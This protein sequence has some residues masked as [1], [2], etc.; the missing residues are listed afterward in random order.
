MTRVQLFIKSVSEEQDPRS[1]QQAVLSPFCWE[2]R[3]PR[4][5]EA[6][7]VL[8]VARE[9]ATALA[10]RLTSLQWD[11]ASC[12]EEEEEEEEAYLIQTRLLLPC[13]QAQMSQAT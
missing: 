3:C 7:A 13:L 5:Q 2:L 4:C 12:V 11:G 1:Q 9:W 10:T 6:P 8:T